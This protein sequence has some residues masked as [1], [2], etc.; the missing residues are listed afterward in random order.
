MKFRSITGSALMLLLLSGTA[1]MTSGGMLSP[2]SDARAN[3]VPHRSVGLPGVFDQKGEAP[4]VLA[5]VSDP[6]VTQLEEEI[7]KLSGTIEELN[8]QVLQ[9]Q[10]QLRKMQEDNEFR[11][12]E[13]EKR[14]EAGA[15][16]N[17]KTEAT[18]PLAKNKTAADT[19]PPPTNNGVAAVTPGDDSTAAPT[20]SQDPALGA[21]PAD[22]GEVTVDKD[23]NIKGAKMG[24][25]QEPAA[26]S[27]NSSDNTT[28]AALPATDD[29]NELY[30]NSYQ[31]ILSG[32]YGTAEAGFRDHIARFPTD[33]KASDAHYWLGESLLGQ[34]KYRDAAETFLAASK[35]YPKAKKAPD[36]LLKL[37]V[38]LV[39][40]KQKDVAC[41]TFG[42]IGKRYPDI[43]A[44]LKERVKQ[45]RALAAC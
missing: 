10:E 15:A 13:L 39:G 37:G 2:R 16:A 42:E 23:G 11:F 6:R 3:P 18:R 24:E 36:M 21:P 19:N 5:Q 43:S 9:M 20:D 31:F 7:R 12:Q 44:A 17:K 28:V 35:D 38:S 40:L 26:G 1:G 41:A 33:P 34:Q 8:F 32:D 4:I 25:P 45:E 22:L 30:R 14:G 27:G 29:P